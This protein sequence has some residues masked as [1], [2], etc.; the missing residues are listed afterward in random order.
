MRSKKTFKNN[1]NTLK[2]KKIFPLAQNMY[3]QASI[4]ITKEGRARAG[5]IIIKNIKKQNYKK[6]KKKEI[7]NL[8]LNLKYHFF[9]V[10]KKEEE[11]NIQL[12][13]YAN[14]FSSIVSDAVILTLFVMVIAQGQCWHMQRLCCCYC[15]ISLLVMFRFCL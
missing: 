8:E 12:L 13:S 1:M 15:M 14:R 2:S 7:N 9:N 11:W 3:V 6:E 4:E 10:K 5:V